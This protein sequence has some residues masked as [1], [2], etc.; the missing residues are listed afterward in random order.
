MMT[1]EPYRP[2]PNFIQRFLSKYTYNLK[3]NVIAALLGFI[4]LLVSYLLISTQMREINFAQME[5]KGNE[6]KRV[7]HQLTD[8][9][10]QHSIYENRMVNGDKNLSIKLTQ[11][12]DKIDSDFKT[13]IALNENVQDDLKTSHH[14]FQLREESKSHP[15]DIYLNWKDHI[16][17]RSIDHAT[18]HHTSLIND[19]R[20]LLTH[21]ADS[22]N[23]S[24]DPEVETHYLIETTVR[25]LPK[26]KDLVSRILI[27]GE[28]LST[29]ASLSPEDSYQLTTLS[30][31]LTSS[32]QVSEEA[33]KKS[34]VEDTNFNK[35]METQNLLSSPLANYSYSVRMFTDYIKDVILTT[36]TTDQANNFQ[37][38]SEEGEQTTASS[39]P[40]T[41]FFNL[42]EKV[43]QRNNE[44][45]ETISDQIDKLLTLRVNAIRTERLLIMAGVFLSLAFA[46][47][48]GYLIISETNYFF[49]ETYKSVV[50]FSNGN[51]SSRAPVAYDKAFESMRSVLNELGERIENLIEQLQQSGVQLTTTTTEI[52]AAAKH[53]EGNVC[54]QEATVKEILVTAGEI[55]STA[56]EFAKTMNDVSVSA[57]ETSSLASFGKDG[58]SKMEQTMRHMV[59]ASKNIASKLAILNEKA[60][61]IT[62]VIT[63]I[64][65][66]AD[67]TNLLSLNASIEAEKAGEHGKSFAVIAREIRR[68]ADQTA[69]ATLDIEQMVSEMMSAVS[70]GVMGVDKFSEEIHTGV[71]QVSTASEQLSLI[72]EGVQQQ[73]TRYENV[74]RGM[75]SQSLGAEQ[76][77]ESIMQLSDAAQETT[78]SIRQF[79]TAI[80]QLTFA[81]KEMQVSVARM[82]K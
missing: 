17:D 65:K 7:V 27:L 82:K 49:R 60:G 25:T 29:Q 42:G 16:N 35:R 11:L 56:K 62:S 76:I 19:L 3:F 46:V 13:L 71:D 78:N 47:G 37:P 20:I 74:N 14:Q 30:S 75:Q 24:Y 9:I 32:V 1:K 52:A 22:S 48:G 23:L 50:N 39:I 45:W 79:H 80:D 63:T 10:T 73:T 33:I 28:K 59:E 34:I 41:E 43:I 44:L 53:Q 15:G 4:I 40:L 21:I 72:I 64:T 2:P 8:S 6:Y 77:N 31:L 12:Q 38:P 81:T 54:E 68:L 70:E 5:I 51:L 67:Q 26:E 61:A 57:E 36:H 18:N 69:N 55:F 66:V 58:L